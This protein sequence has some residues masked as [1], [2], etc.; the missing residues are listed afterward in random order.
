M[1]LIFFLNNLI[2]VHLLYNRCG[3]SI[4]KHSLWLIYFPT[5]LSY[6]VKFS[7]FHRLVIYAQGLAVLALVTAHDG[8]TVPHIDDVDVIINHH[9]HDCTWTSPIHRGCFLLGLCKSALVVIVEESQK[10]FISLM[11]AFEYWFLYFIW[12]FRLIYYIVMKTVLQVLRASW[13][14]MPVIYSE[15]L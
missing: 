6:S 10:S 14:P 15:Y 12:K 13:P 11:S 7:G 3:I 5:I 8:S 1:V 4:L 2:N 9:D